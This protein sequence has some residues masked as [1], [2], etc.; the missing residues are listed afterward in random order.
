M[1][2]TYIHVNRNRIASNLK[3]GTCEPVITIKTGRKNTYCYEVEILGPSRVLYN[4]DG[5]LSCGAK[6]VIETESECRVIR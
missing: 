4:V 5:I 1:A 6:A 2:K 3:H